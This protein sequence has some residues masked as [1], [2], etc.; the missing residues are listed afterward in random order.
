VFARFFGKS[1]GELI[2]RKWH[3]AVHAD[4]LAHIE[5][6]LAGL[7]PD[8]P[9][10]LVENR[11]YSGKG[12][13]HW[14]QFVN[15]ASFDEA[16]NVTEV[17]SVG[18]DIS[19]TRALQEALQQLLREK[20]AILDNEL[21]GIMTS[22]ARIV[23]WANP[24][25]EKMFGY[26]HGELAGIP[27]RPLYPDDEAWQ[28][29]AADAY[30]KL[31]SGK[32]FNRCAEFVRKD[33]QRVWMDTSGTMLDKS[34]GI[35]LWCLVDVTARKR[36]E[37]ELAQYRNR[38]EAMVE[39]RTAALSIAKEAAEAANRAKTTFL[40]KMSHELRTPMNGIMGMT[41]LSLRRATDR[42]QVS[43]L[44]ELRKCS[45]G[46]MTLIDDILDL[47][48]IEAERLT[49][50]M[51][52]FLLL[53]V[54]H[55]LTT[56][57]AQHAAERGLAFSVD[58]PSTLSSLAL[59]GDPLRLTQILLN[60]VGN[61]LKFTAQGAVVVRAR[62]VEHPPQEVLLRFE[63]CDTGVGI[64]FADHERI[65][66]AFEQIDDSVTRS[67]GGS[68]LGLAICK[69]LVTMMG[70]QIGVDSQPGQGSTF[71]FSVR[72]ALADPLGITALPPRDSREAERQ[73][74]QGHRGAH[75]LLVEDEP[76]NREVARA[77]LEGAG[78]KVDVAANGL[79]AVNRV[80]QSAYALILMDLLMPQMDGISAARA[81]RRLPAGQA[82][83]IIALTA[84]VL[85]EERE[86]CLAAGMNDFLPKPVR[87]EALYAMV[88][89]WLKPR[90]E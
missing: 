28:T 14:M 88:L 2:G 34:A 75:I 19:R 37:D 89:R 59:R 84:N 33:G 24:A 1:V 12:E 38:L 39:E 41:E 78:L 56:L 62:R 29:F 40:T 13:V 66:S 16:G 49:L 3:P 43:Q 71:W 83:P 73:L 53:D 74:T 80:R 72:L 22:R 7:S 85:A 90:G 8:N 70:G 23:Q 9:V 44:G 32:A 69:R 35:S 36:D 81:I 31:H 65:F 11:V 21:I 46:L 61:A 87:P 20:D 60:L 18:R 17:Q 57:M 76:I 58:I 26:A 45:L 4:D 30:P 15:R 47:S 64:P 79:D 42:V 67:H 27:T 10:I 82:V 25:L 51:S 68:G 50:E 48:R 54:V 55:K 6:G 77:Q 63:I 86:K 5:T 52:D